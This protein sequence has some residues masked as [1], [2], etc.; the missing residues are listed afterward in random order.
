[1]MHL[2]HLLA[3]ETFFCCWKILSGL[4][5][6]RSVKHQASA[7]T[8]WLTCIP[9]S[10]HMYIIKHGSQGR[11]MLF[12]DT[13][14]TFVFTVIWIFYMH[15]HTYWI[16]FRSSIMQSVCLFWQKKPIKNKCA[17]KLIYIH[18]SPSS[19]I[20]SGKGRQCTRYLW[21]YGKGPFT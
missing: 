5:L 6:V 4:Q 8:K 13:F 19:D 16:N 20:W 12:I 15:H 3:S 7:L 14:K 1:M 17:V 21:L 10:M 2:I 9:R 18:H 11:K